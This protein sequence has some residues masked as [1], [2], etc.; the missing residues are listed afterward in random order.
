MDVLKQLIPAEMLNYCQKHGLLR[1]VLSLK[2][3]ATGMCEV[4]QPLAKRFKKAVP[5]L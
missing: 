5:G 4:A 1:G 2:R 3:A